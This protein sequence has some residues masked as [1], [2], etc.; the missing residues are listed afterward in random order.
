MAIRMSSLI[1]WSTISH[2][3]P[4]DAGII[5]AM[6]M[7]WRKRV[8]HCI[9]FKMDDVVIAEQIVVIAKQIDLLNIILCPWS[10]WECLSAHTIQK[11]FDNCGFNESYSDFGHFHWKN[12]HQLMTIETSGSIE[13]YELLEKAISIKKDQIKL[14]LVKRQTL[15]NN[16]LEPKSVVTIKVVG[17]I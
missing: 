6:K 15:E 2:L 5:Q 13:D 14:F 10:T 11:S 3:Q 12:I 8:F 17:N 9:L 1:I 4:C 7:N 16:I